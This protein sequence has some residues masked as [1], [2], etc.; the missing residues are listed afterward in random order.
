M[1]KNAFNYPIKKQNYLVC[2][3]KASNLDLINKLNIKVIFDMPKTLY[4]K[5]N[6]K[7]NVNKIFMTTLT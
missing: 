5:R 6:R 3:L 7:F 4:T 2:F 1:E